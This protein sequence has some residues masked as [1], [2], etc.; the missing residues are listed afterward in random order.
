MYPNWPAFPKIDPFE[1]LSYHKNMQNR[2][3]C[4]KINKNIVPGLDGR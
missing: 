2:K 1:S 3:K 4:K